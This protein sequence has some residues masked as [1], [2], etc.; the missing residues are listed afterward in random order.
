MISF[1][2]VFGVNK[3]NGLS[4]FELSIETTAKLI[5]LVDMFFSSQSQKRTP[6]GSKL[7]A[8]KNLELDWI[9]TQTLKMME[10]R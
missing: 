10:R 1:L 7:L 4:P 9:L 2:Q 3:T 6:K 8:D 5:E